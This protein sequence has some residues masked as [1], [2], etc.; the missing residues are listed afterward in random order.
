LSDLKFCDYFRREE[1]RQRLRDGLRK[2]GF[3]D[4]SN[5]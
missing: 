1:D 4:S 2:A 5:R 3:A